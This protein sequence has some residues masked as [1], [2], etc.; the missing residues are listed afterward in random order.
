MS[1]FLASLFLGHIAPIDYS[2]ASGM[3]LMELRSKKW[4]PG[5]L[6]LCGPNAAEK[7][8]N[9]VPSCSNLGNISPYFVE[10][11]GFDKSCEVFA[12]SGDNPSSLIGKFFRFQSLIFIS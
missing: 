4:H 1:S 7:L 8:G 5:L 10:R 12:F 3:N 11:Y 2:D 6:K 9:P